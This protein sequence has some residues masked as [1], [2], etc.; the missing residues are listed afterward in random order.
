MSFCDQAE[1]VRVTGHQVVSRELTGVHR[2]LDLG[3][4]PRP[5]C[6]S[7]AG[8]RETGGFRLS[9]AGY[10]ESTDIVVIAASHNLVGRTRNAAPQ[11]RLSWAGMRGQV[12]S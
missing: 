10:A 11:F 5:V 1:G 12:D 6:P 9:G 7:G 3:F 8:G 2:V 4:W